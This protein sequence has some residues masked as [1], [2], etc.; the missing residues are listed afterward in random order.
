MVTCVVIF[1]RQP[2]RAV[3]C[4]V[5]FTP[6]DFYSCILT[7]C[8][9]F[10][11]PCYLSCFQANTN[12]SFCKSF[13][14]ITIRIAWGVGGRGATLDLNLYLKSLT[15]GPGKG[16]R[17]SLMSE[18]IRPQDE[19]DDRIRVHPEQD[20]ADKGHKQHSV[21]ANRERHGANGGGFRTRLAHVHHHDH[22]QLV[23]RADHAV[24]G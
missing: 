18:Q 19:I 23:V 16:R 3:P 20:G 2:R 6:S 5:S 14:L 24:E 15:E 9:A 8:F 10:F 21:H 13:V 17:R 7:S 12:C 4:C 22:A 1:R 11:A